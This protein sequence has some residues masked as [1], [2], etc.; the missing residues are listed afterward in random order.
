VLWADRAATGGWYG[1]KSNAR[2]PQLL[3]TLYARSVQSPA[4]LTFPTHS[5]Y[6]RHLH[7]AH[8]IDGG[9]WAPLYHVLA[10]EYAHDGVIIP[11]SARM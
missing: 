2:G 7:D 8:E 6:L 4:L 1:P 9:P 10:F 3:A 5:A 11:R